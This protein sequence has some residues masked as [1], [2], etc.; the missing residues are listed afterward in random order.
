MSEETS[1]RK[2]PL[3][4]A[5]RVGLSAAVVSCLAAVLA[6]GLLAGGGYLDRRQPQ[7]TNQVLGAFRLYCCPWNWQRSHHCHC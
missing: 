5:D 7:P 6:Y 1:P 3:L 4:P 2:E